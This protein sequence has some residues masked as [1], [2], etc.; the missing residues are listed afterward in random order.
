MSNNY[1][2]NDNDSDDERIQLMELDEHNEEVEVN[3]GE[4]SHTNQRT[5]RHKSR[6][7][8]IDWL[9]IYASF[10]VIF[11][12]TSFINIP[13]NFGEYNWKVLF[14][15]NSFAR[16][17]VPLFMMISGLLF[18]NPSKVIPL[19]TLYSKYVYRIFISLVFWTLYYNIINEYVV[20]VHRIDFHFTKNE[21]ER[22]IKRII[23][24]Q[25]SGHLWY[26]YFCIGIYMVTPL[27]KC[28]TEKRE[29]AWYITLLSVSISQ[30][31]PSLTNLLRTYTG[32]LS[33]SIVNDVI[34]KVNIEVIGNNSSYYLLGYLLN[35]HVFKNK[36]IIK[37]SYAMGIIGQILTVILRFDMCRRNKKEVMDFAYAFDF[38]VM[39]IVIGTFMFF[40]HGISD[41][42]NNVMNNNRF[43][44]KLILILSDCSFGIYLGHMAIYDI[45]LTFFNFKPIT[46]NPLIW[47]PIYSVILFIITAFTIYLL[48]FI[49]FFRKVT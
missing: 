44:N 46:F 18:L 36:M 45:L 3:I 11:Q 33:L 37:L 20:N 8:W 21:I 24:G 35:T 32:I 39:M 27:Y 23:L 34:H 16:H 13:R 5:E 9:R 6:V 29:I 47:Q 15:Y 28:L 49:P 19:K 42:I 40:K 30:V 2:I 48:R 22:C 1:Q 17:C 43:V 38:N 41:W 25:N 10:I 7:Y 4:S 26:L 31:I 12:H 14:F